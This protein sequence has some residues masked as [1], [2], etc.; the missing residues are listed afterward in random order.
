MSGRLLSGAVLSQFIR[1]R[2]GW[3]WRPVIVRFIDGI[4]HL[5]LSVGDM[6]LLLL[7]LVVALQWAKARSP[8]IADRHG[9]EDIAVRRPPPVSSRA[10]REDRRFS[11]PQPR[12]AS[13]RNE[14]RSIRGDG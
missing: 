10:S 11:F 12:P 2:F 5:V 7:V 1:A 4:R 8:A 14:S 3:H 13:V 9:L 6:Y